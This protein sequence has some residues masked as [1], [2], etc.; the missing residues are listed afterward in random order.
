MEQKSR[1]VWTMVG[2]GGAVLT[3]VGIYFFLRS[4]EKQPAS[5]TVKRVEAI[6]KE[7]EDLIKHHQ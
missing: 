5:Q 4:L 3:A 7:A 1:G 2:L 6:I